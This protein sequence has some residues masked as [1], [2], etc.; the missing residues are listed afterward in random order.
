MK[1]REWFV[2]SLVY[3]AVFTCEEK[4]ANFLSAISTYKIVINKYFVR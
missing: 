1:L 2:V 4:L 3:M